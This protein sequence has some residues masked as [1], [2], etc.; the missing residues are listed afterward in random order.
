MTDDDLRR[1]LTTVG[2]TFDLGEYETE[3]YVTVLEHGRLTATELADRT[4]IPQ[5]RVYDT[6]R[7]LAEHGFV[8]VHE[9]RPMRI[10]AVDPTEAFGDV[11]TTLADLVEGLERRYTAPS[12]GTEAASLVKSRRTILRYLED[13]ITT[14]E[15]ELLIS[16]TPDLFSRFEETLAERR[17]EG[18]AVDLLLSPA[19]EVPDADAYDYTDVAS[20]VRARR[21]VTTPIAAVADGEYSIYTAREAV[22][23]GPERYGVVFN[24]SDL[25][26]LVSGFLN[27]VVW[28]S[29][30]TLL[31]RADG[32]PYPRRYASLRRCVNDLSGRDTPQYVTV[33][34][35][36]VETGEPRTVEGRIVDV[37]GDRS[38]MTAS[39]TVRTDD[40]EVAVGGQAAAFEDV[41]AT[42]LVVAPDEPP[43]T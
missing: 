10:V 35:R 36:D 3:A 25:G 17:A 4:D 2:E 26:L 20:S 22:R 30:T 1:M 13:V 15:Y 8:E 19:A 33:R 34:G 38:R 14:A 42:E 9:S 23:T 7:G 11:R 18:V 29:A 28:G 16:L 41:E 5:P 39:L 24:R 6:V 31:D 27:T 32:R 21:G 12:R 37:A 43:G 40:G